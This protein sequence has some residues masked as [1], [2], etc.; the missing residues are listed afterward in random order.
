MRIK[1]PVARIAALAVF[2]IAA[3][4]PAPA[5]IKSGPYV[6]W[7]V[8]EYEFFGLTKDQVQKKF[9]G[10]LC[11]HAGFERVH[12]KGGSGLNY[13]G[14]TFK[15]GFN[16]GLVDTVQGIFEG[17]RDT[18]YRPFF[19]SKK[20]ALKFACDG[21]ADAKDEAGKKKLAAARKELA[22]VEASP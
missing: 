14:P 2:M 11:F 12:F 21:L 17:C 8:D 20:D 18:I 10:R 3:Q 5:E 22:T 13:Y 1:L 9:A 16:N 15:L 6:D 4:T 19:K 7:G